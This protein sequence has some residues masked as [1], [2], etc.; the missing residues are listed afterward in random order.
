VSKSTLPRQLSGERQ[1]L[2][3]MSSLLDALKR[4]RTERLGLGKGW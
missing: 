2:K 1:R 4:A 3:P